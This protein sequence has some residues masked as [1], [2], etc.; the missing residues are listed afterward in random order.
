MAGAGFSTFTTEWVDGAL[1]IYDSAH[2]AIVTINSTGLV[3][4]GGPTISSAILI[5]GVT[6]S[7]GVSLDGQVITAAE[8][9]ITC[10]LSTGPQYSTST[11]GVTFT[12]PVSSTAIGASFTFINKSP[13]ATNF[14]RIITNTSDCFAG[15]G[16]QTASTGNSVIRNT[17]TSHVVGD[18]VKITALNTGSGGGGTFWVINDMVGVWTVG[19]AT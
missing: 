5:S 2:T 13:A 14:M 16:I 7:S 19:A 10:A 3:W 18:F 11:D 6:V 1:V 12:L 15:Y 8:A 9:S 4:A 17:S